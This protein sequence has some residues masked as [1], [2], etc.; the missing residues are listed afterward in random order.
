MSG[1]KVSGGKVSGGKISGGKVSHFSGSDLTEARYLKRLF[2]CQS[3][4]VKMVDW[5]NSSR[6]Q[7]AAFV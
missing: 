1:G 7:H 5:L 4:S 6:V 3:R 2:R